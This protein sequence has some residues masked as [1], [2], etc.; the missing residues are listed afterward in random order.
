MSFRF[1]GI[2][3]ILSGFLYLSV[4][5]ISAEAQDQTHGTGAFFDQDRYL[6]VPAAPPLSR[7]DYLGNPKQVSLKP[8]TPPVGDQGK[9]GSCVAWA[10]AYAGRTLLEAKAAEQKDKDSIRPMRFSPAFIYNQIQD[11][12]CSPGGS[13]IEDAL[14][15]MQSKGVAKLSDFPY[16]PHNCTRQPDSGVLSR[17]SEHK[18]RTFNRLW[19]ARGRNRHSAVRRALA[20]GHPVVIGMWVMESFARFNATD[21]K[22]TEAE[23][24]HLEATPAYERPLKALGGHAMTVVGYDD[25][26]NGG[27]LEIMNSYGTNWGNNGFF[28]MSYDAFNATVVQGYEMIPKDPP[29][30]P[31]P[32]KVVDMAGEFRMV[33]ISG[34]WL[35][36]SPSGNA[37][38]LDESLPSGTRFRAEAS[39]RY[40][41]Y[42][43]VIGGDK[44]GEF[45]ELFPRTERVSPFVPKTKTLLL[46]GPT[47]AHFTRLNDSVGT[48][49]Y[50]MLVAQS[51]LN[52]ASIA[53]GMSNVA[54]TVEQKLRSVLG[55]RMVS[56]SDIE[57]QRDKIGFE[58]KSGEADVVPIIISIDHVAPD[59]ATAD[60]TGPLIVL[61]SPA[62]E[63]FDAGPD[64]Q[65]PIVVASRY[66]QIDGNAQDESKIASLTV[67]GAL[68]SKFS[69]RGPFRAE[70]E[71]PEG[72]GPHKVPV[73]AQDA[74]GNRS[75][76]TFQFIVKP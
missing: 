73:E 16:D 65:E 32:E 4:L 49:Y 61:T 15:V 12:G 5:P 29:P 25:T 42:F 7:G 60:K 69:S 45:V 44:S 13:L 23:F 20:D 72:P 40:P 70:L 27:S 8:Y 17:A 50:V 38:K 24:D 51:P 75:Q 26:R 21:Y 47:E 3:R 11:S 56:P 52:I 71:L 19:G 62:E 31:E 53:S 37:Y 1:A 55:D 36:A 64:R 43:Y 63:S 2:G 22:P 34:E 41:A 6:A 10:T 66:L 18:I 59:P 58:A 39:S 46:P 48:D 35:T 9:Q 67:Q 30:P 74:A 14:H 57:L 28:W 76:T 33:H 54:G 68:S